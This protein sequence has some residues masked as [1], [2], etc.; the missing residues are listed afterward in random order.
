M[1]QNLPN[2][3]DYFQDF[4]KRDLTILYNKSDS[5]N[6]CNL[7]KMEEIPLKNLSNRE[8]IIIRMADKGGAVTI[9]DSELY[10]SLNKCMLDDSNTYRQLS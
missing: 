2:S 9:L 5:F 6:T 3:R 10:R 1:R 4:V 7:N 8:D